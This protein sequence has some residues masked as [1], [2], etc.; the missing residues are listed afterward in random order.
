MLH[1][2][3]RT[4]GMTRCLC[5]WRCHHRYKAATDDMSSF[6]DITV[7]NNRCGGQGFAPLCCSSGYGAG[8][9]WDAASGLGSPNYPVLLKQ[10]LMYGQA[11][12]ARREALKQ[13][14]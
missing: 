1:S 7:G 8:V 2:T 12:K 10:A 6:N 13:A 3:C 11:A 5:V 9:G 14:A 4:S